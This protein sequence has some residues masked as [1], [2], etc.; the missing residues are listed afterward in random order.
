M[1]ALKTYKAKAWKMIRSMIQVKSSISRIKKKQPRIKI[2][3]IP[4][5]KR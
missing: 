4:I 5:V 1:V 2:G 3:I